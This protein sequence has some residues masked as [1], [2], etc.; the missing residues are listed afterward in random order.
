[1]TTKNLN[2]NNFL[3]FIIH[4]VYKLP[5]V[6]LM[7][8]DIPLVVGSITVAKPVYGYFKMLNILY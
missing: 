8:D 6:P 7:S 1:V 2:I 5:V 4:F 3:K